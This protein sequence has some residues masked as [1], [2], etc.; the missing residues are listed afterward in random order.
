MRSKSQYCCMHL[1]D[2]QPQTTLQRHQGAIEILILLQTSLRN[3]PSN[4][5]PKASKCNVNLIS[6]A[7]IPPKCNFKTFLKVCKMQL[8][9]QDCCRHP[10]NRHPQTIIKPF[11][12]GSK[13]QW[14]NQN[15]CR[16]PSNCT[17][18]SKHPPKASACS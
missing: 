9:S 18:K 7:D 2:M 13:I 8:Q 15:C 11:L 10:F 4:H 1:F 5:S 17:L 14:T 6:A 12:N 3:A 16:Y